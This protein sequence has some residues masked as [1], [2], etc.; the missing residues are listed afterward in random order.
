MP[1]SSGWFSNVDLAGIA[2]AESRLGPG[3]KFRVKARAARGRKIGLK[4]RKYREIPD[5]HTENAAKAHIRSVWGTF[6]KKSITMAANMSGRSTDAI[7]PAGI[8]LT[9]AWGMRLRISL[10]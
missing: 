9:S 2:A 8:M 5:R 7:W 3:G 6:D 4:S 1:G 10:P